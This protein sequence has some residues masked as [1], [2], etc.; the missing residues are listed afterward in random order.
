MD[1]WEDNVTSSLQRIYPNYEVSVD[2]DSDG[3]LQ[4]IFVAVD[5]I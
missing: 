1:T 4:G 3:G 2:Y 5:L